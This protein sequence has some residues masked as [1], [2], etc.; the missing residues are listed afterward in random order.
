MKCSKCGA[1]FEGQFCPECGTPASSQPS[2][3]K[4]QKKKKGCLWVGLIILGVII[5]IGV[6]SQ[7]FGK[8]FK[9][10]MSASSASAQAASKAVPSSAVSSKAVTAKEETSYG[11]GQP[12]AAHGITMTLA[13]VTESK[14]NEY[15]TPADGKVFLLCEFNIDNKSSKDLAISSIACF[16]AY[17]DGY[18]TD[19][20]LTGLIGEGSKQQLDGSVAA[21]KKMNG[22]IAYEVPKNWKELEIQVNP[23]V[24]SI[25]SGKTIFK[26]V[27]K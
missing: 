7:S 3:K 21:G 18:A 17:A 5:V 25:F 9:D 10:G 6:T 26:V 23:D 12:A 24:L 8:G 14:G 27:H 19:Q 13:S 4:P 22:V 16:E 2:E 15:N 11:I 20:S 1:E